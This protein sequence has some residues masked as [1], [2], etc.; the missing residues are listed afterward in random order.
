MPPSPPQNADDASY[1]AEVQPTFALFLDSRARTLWS[2]ANERGFTPKDVVA[3][4][5]VGASS[6]KGRADQI[7]QKGVGW[8]AT[9]TV[10]STPAVVSG[11]FRFEFDAATFIIPRWLERHS[12][13]LR[14][15]PDALC[16]LAAPTEARCDGTVVA[17]PLDS[18]EA[19]GAPL[20]SERLR[21]EVQQEVLLFLRQLTH[22]QLHDVSARQHVSM[23][24]ASLDHRGEWQPRRLPQAE[25]HRIE[26]IVV[27]SETTDVPEG[28]VPEGSPAAPATDAPAAS[29]YFVQSATFAVPDHLRALEPR[30][31]H[32]QRTTVQLVFRVESRRAD[33][34]ADDMDDVDGA[35]SSDWKLSSPVEEY[36]F[37]FLP[38]RR[39]GLRFIA[40]ADWLL[41]SSREDVHDCA[42]N[43]WLRDRLAEVKSA[44]MLRTL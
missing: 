5:N 35:S 19:L 32:A 15:W 13:Q 28:Y 43:C 30:R 12:P 26:R 16:A 10:S 22:L 1:T 44:C 14:D 6:K 36:L 42:W 27:A 33:G 17:L 25:L 39:V 31:A 20:D 29:C 23:S 3:I 21:R 24:I 11:P 9:F 4:S 7:G 37:A 38:V 2:H 8:K 18:A 34:H 41:V 40:N